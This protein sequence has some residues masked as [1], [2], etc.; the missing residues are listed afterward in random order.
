LFLDSEA[1]DIGET[2]IRLALKS[3]VYIAPRWI[4]PWNR[5]APALST[6]LSE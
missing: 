6:R 5:N 4:S 3:E 1:E 2:Y